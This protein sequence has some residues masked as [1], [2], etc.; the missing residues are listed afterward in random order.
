MADLSLAR[1][2]LVAALLPERDP[3]SFRLGVQEIS[4]PSV[5][6]AVWGV[7]TGVAMVKSGLSIPLAFFMTFVAFAGSAQLAVLP[8]LAERSPIPI[9]WITAALVNIR[10]VIF[11]AAM[12]PYFLVLPFRQRLFASYWN[13]D[14]GSALFMRH[15]ANATS[16]GNPSQWG[17]YYGGATTNW[18]VWQASSCLGIVLGSRFPASWGLDLGAVLA[19]VAVLIPMIVKRPI[20]VGVGVTTVLSVATAQFPLRSGLLLSVILGIIAAMVAEG[21]DPSGDQQ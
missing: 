20:A 14:V 8:L 18:L 16:F 11:S 21:S 17:Y 7:V 13:G 4:T 19:L 1:R 6:I 2:S 15:H 10:F 3:T 5:G 9:V 12:R